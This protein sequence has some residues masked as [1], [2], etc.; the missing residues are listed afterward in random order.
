MTPRPALSRIT[1]HVNHP[2]SCVPR[3]LLLFL[4]ICREEKE[5]QGGKDTP[6]CL[7]ALAL[8]LCP[9][10]FGQ[11]LNETRPLDS[12]SRANTH[13]YKLNQ[14][15]SPPSL[16]LLLLL[17]PRL[18][19]RAPAATPGQRPNTTRRVGLVPLRGPSAGRCD[20]TGH[21]P[22]PVSSRVPFAPTHKN[23]IRKGLS[24]S[25]P[26]CPPTKSPNTYPTLFRRFRFVTRS[27]PI[28]FPL[29]VWISPRMGHSWCGISFHIFCCCYCALI[30][31]KTPLAPSPPTM[32][33]QPGGK[34]A[35]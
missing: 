27:L 16:W 3:F 21:R 20:G 15:A 14:P 35:L 29:A 1:L 8:A 22:P 33:M 28:P 10:L 24:S 4:L 17:L 13:T 25:S 7:P 5:G 19:V 31:H 23:T 2:Y 34:H 12:E 18:S 6:A 11:K 32:G 26:R 9:L 30:N